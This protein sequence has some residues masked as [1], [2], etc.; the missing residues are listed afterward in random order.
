MQRLRLAAGARSWACDQGH[1]FDVASEGYVNLLLSSQRRSRKPGDSGEMVAARRRFLDSGAYDPMTTALATAVA[2]ER[3]TLLLDVGCGEGRHTRQM[4]APLVLGFDV[5]KPAVAKAAK[6]HA[7]GWYAV[8]S[9][10]QIPLDDASVDVA[11]NV[12]G[13]VVPDELARVVR[14]GGCVVTAGPGPRHLAEMRALVYKD[15]RPHQV[16]PPLRDARD[17]FAEVSRTGLTFTV[18]AASLQQLEDLFA[19]TPYRWHAPPDIRDCLAEVAA[20]G[21]GVTADIQL[22]VY[23]RTGRSAGRPD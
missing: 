6:A 23:R 18:P 7:E 14:T 2:E 3:P 17:W 12:F 16:K 15:A 4:P 13:P 1:N 10:A 22:T 11:V 21:F 5:S 19:M 20:S 8:A 9:A